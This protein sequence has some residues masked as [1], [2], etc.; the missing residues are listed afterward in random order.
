MPAMD[1]ADI[2]S[3]LK[4]PWDRPPLYGYLLLVFGPPVATTSATSRTPR[5]DPSPLT[6]LQ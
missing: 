6:P 2:G 5:P 3:L 4:E 1:R